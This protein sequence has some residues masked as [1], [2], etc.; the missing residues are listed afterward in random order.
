MSKFLPNF[1]AA[2][3]QVAHELDTTL[4]GLL[5]DY[6]GVEPADV[7]LEHL[8]QGTWGSTSTG[9]QDTTPNVV[10]INLASAKHYSRWRKDVAVSALLGE[11][12]QVAQPS[13][14]PAAYTMAHEYGHVLLDTIHGYGYNTDEDE[15]AGK[16][17][18]ASEIARREYVLTA[19]RA[20]HPRTANH[21]SVNQVPDMWNQ[22]FLAMQ[23]A[24]DLSE[25]G[26][27]SPEEMVA[28][29]FVI[30]R[31]A[32]GKS[33]VADAVAA[34]LKAN[35]ETWHAAQLAKQAA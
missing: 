10:S 15:A 30:H 6:P 21:L 3:K 17:V 23:L 5:A 13:F 9:Y 12:N 29:A 11:L 14:D 28:E 35:Y 4:D 7:K 26:A 19:W 16:P 2:E 24:N 32:P 22:R 25:Y 27:S 20:L 1:A 31:R 33:K 18:P 34:Q 8:P